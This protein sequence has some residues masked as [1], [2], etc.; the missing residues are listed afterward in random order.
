MPDNRVVAETNNNELLNIFVNE[1]DRKGTDLLAMS[2]FFTIFVEKL[3]YSMQ[4]DSNWIP[5]SSNIEAFIGR[6]SA[7]IKSGL[8]VSQMGTLIADSSH[9]SRDIVDGLRKGIY[10]IGQSKEVAGNL[11]PAII[12][13][14]GQL[15]KFF[16][17]KK[18]IDPSAVLS[19]IT[20]LSMQTALQSISMQIEEIGQS[21]QEMID[22]TR[23][24]NLSNK[25]LFAREKIKQAA[26]ANE[27]QQERILDSADTYLMEGLINIETDLQDQISKLYEIKHI[28]KLDS[29][30]SYIIEDMQM[31]PKYVGLKTYLLNYRGKT[32]EAEQALDDFRY[33]LQTLAEKK[34]D[35]GKFTA[36]ELIHRYY[37]YS[38]NNQDFWL[39]S[40]QKMLT[41]IESSK[42]LLWQKNK[43]VY[44]I[45]VEVN[46]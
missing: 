40:P 29:I 3:E 8:D 42:K 44:Y 28:K 13:D 37:P 2:D 15:V 24:V 27:S 6:I 35:S 45:D 22:L 17:L 20:T 10:H 32:E 31:L 46:E 41:A 21:I 12:D 19:N 18:A 7:A 11:R 23:R 39:S 25:F 1:E 26:K 36:F 38:I 4:N 30:L 14:K 9:F 43:E 16:T 33:F 34:I 5:V